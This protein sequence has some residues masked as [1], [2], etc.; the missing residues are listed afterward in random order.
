LSV[1]NTAGVGDDGTGTI[2]D[3]GTGT[4]FTA[5]G[6]IDNDA[7]KNDDRPPA[8]NIV[9]N[10]F[11]PK[12]I[13]YPPL[14]MGRYEFNAVVL[15]FNGSHGGINQFRLPHVDTTGSRQSLSYSNTTPYASYDRVSD[16]VENA[17][18][19]TRT[20]GALTPSNDIGL[21][22]PLLPPDAKVG[23][24]G[25]AAYLLPSGTFVGGKGDIKLTAFTKDGKPLPDWIKFSPVDGKF[26]I[27]MPNGIRDSIELEIIATDANGDQARTKINIKPAPIARVESLDEKR[28]EKIEAKADDKK[29]N[30]SFGSKDSFTN[31]IKEALTRNWK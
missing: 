9:Q 18:R 6:A 30:S 11:T 5:T 19:T 29:V 14:L 2:N 25:K 15:N 12:P 1:F 10:V 7:I 26:D 21:R 23:A 24:D 20:D 22:N 4:I 28:P 3:D 13:E 8:R 16:A 17:Q 31:Q 27:A